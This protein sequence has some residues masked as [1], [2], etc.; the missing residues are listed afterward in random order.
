VLVG[1]TLLAIDKTCRE[2]RTL[3]DACYRQTSLQ[4]PSEIQARIAHSMDSSVEKRISPLTLAIE[5]KIEAISVVQKT[6]SNLIEGTIR[7]LGA[8]IKRHS[9]EIALDLGN[10]FN[11]LS[12]S[13][14]ALGESVKRN[15]SQ[16]RIMLEAVQNH[17]LESRTASV[18]VQ[19]IIS[20]LSIRQ[21]QSNDMV[22]R[23]VLE[24]G[25]TTEYLIE[26]NDSV[27]QEQV[28]SLHRK[29]D[30]M[31]WLID[32]VKEQQPAQLSISNPEIRNA[33]DKIQRSVWMLVS[34]LHILIRE[35]M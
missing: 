29:L 24:T 15:E 19:G 34:A 8:G 33:I 27:L 11:T 25:G 21:S 32:T 6:S 3:T 13:D 14:K 28:S 20:D 16:S 5:N 17:T 35:L 26:K 23:R 12:L 31:N 7:D 10:K 30:R 1:C 9:H 22:L 4:L 18:T 2:L